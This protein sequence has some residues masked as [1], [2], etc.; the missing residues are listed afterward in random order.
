MIDRLDSLLNYMDSIRPDIV[1]GSIR[2]MFDSHSR[3]CGAVWELRQPKAVKP[4][5]YK[6]GQDATRL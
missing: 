5:S 2:V 3:I 6:A 4:K 1:P